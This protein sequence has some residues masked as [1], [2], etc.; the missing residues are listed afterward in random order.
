MKKILLVDDSPTV[1]MLQKALLKSD[2]LTFVT[3]SDGVQAIEV[4][5]RER[6]DVILLDIVMP[7]MDG[8]AACRA[9]REMPETRTTPILMVTTRSDDAQ[10]AAA[11]AAG[12]TG[13][14]LK[15]FTK[16]E[17]M[18]K[19]EEVMTRSGEEQVRNT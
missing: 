2:S 15:P 3:A 8:I 5:R 13:Y 1:L 18:A 11:K 17:V 9:L 4:A 6:P 16:A 12:C 19:L 10:M 7:N 14:L